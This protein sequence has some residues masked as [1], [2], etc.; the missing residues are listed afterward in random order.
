MSLIVIPERSRPRGF[1]TVGVSWWF[2]AGAKE[3]VQFR[4]RCLLCDSVIVLEPCIMVCC[5]E[6]VQIR[7]V[8]GACPCLLLG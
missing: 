5:V 7:A 4:Q 1:G 3:R 2:R 8:C 6:A